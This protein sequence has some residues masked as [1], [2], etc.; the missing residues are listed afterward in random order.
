[1]VGNNGEIYVASCPDSRP[2]GDHCLLAGADGNVNQAATIT[3]GA[4]TELNFPGV[5]RI[6]A[7][8]QI[9]V[10]NESSITVYP[11]G[12]NR[13]VPPL[14]KIAGAKT[15]L[16]NLAGITLDT[17]RN[18]YVTQ[19]APHFGTISVFDSTAK[20]DTRPDAT[21]TFH[22]PGP[23]PLSNVA[24]DPAGNMYVA[25]FNDDRH[26]RSVYLCIYPP[27]SHG[28]ALQITA[29]MVWIFIPREQSRWIPTGIL[30]C[31]SW[32]STFRQGRYKNL[33]WARIHSLWQ[34]QAQAYFF[35][36]SLGIRMF[37]P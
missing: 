5:S 3:D 24:V 15:G 29:F 28:L 16:T 22:G 11:K 18:I 8:G 19:I 34:R 23:L 6:N 14:F 25:S 27:D 32:I 12:T 4:D 2:G 33:P 13:N 37:L 20:G 36:T 26:R 31:R 30:C 7:D 21:I 10:A 17:Q 9:Y 35:P 1:M